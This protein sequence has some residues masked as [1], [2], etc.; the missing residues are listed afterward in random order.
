MVEV[1]ISG[2]RNEAGRFYARR[3]KEIENDDKTKE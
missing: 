3:K 2:L 1:A